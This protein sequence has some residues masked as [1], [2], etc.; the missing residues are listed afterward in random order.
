MAGVV[1]PSNHIRSAMV[2][3]KKDSIFEECT[4]NYADHAFDK[5]EARRF[6]VALVEEE[7][8]N[9]WF[10]QVVLLF[11]LSTPTNDQMSG[12]SAIIRFSEITLLIDDMGHLS[13]CPRLRWAADDDIDHN[14]NQSFS[15]AGVMEAGEQDRVVTFCSVISVHHVVR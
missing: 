5:S 3:S 8:S 13:N 4:M 14:G 9:C 10:P 6:S 12:D 15:G 2:L 11:Y 1:S 7:G